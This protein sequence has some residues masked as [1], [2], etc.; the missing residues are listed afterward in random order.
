M[1]VFNKESSQPHP[2]DFAANFVKGKMYYGLGID[3]LAEATQVSPADK[4]GLYDKLQN[5]CSNL[6]RQ[7]IPYFN[8]AINHIDNIGAE[9]K[10]EYNE[11]LNYCL[12][13]LNT[14]Y[15]RLE[16]YAELKPIKARIPN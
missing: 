1:E 7:S 15:T 2:N 12:N 6:F 5:E 3:K 9:G 14:V 13:A 11:V 8:N 4:T 16:M 10:G